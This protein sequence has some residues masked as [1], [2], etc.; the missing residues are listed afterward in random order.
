MRAIN[1]P[2]RQP[3]PIGR[4][5]CDIHPGAPGAYKQSPLTPSP[6]PRCTASSR[7]P[8]PSARPSQAPCATTQIDYGLKIRDH[9]GIFVCDRIN[10]SPFS[11]W[12]KTKCAASGN[13]FLDIR[14]S[15]AVWVDVAYAISAIRHFLAKANGRLQ[16]G[17]PRLLLL[18]SMLG[19]KKGRT[20]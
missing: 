1:A 10:R 16:A 3:E 15:L 4:G 19:P 17:V 2:G 12:M 20:S 14:D 6:G 18:C 9:Q 11:S 7:P 13:L 5:R 8:N